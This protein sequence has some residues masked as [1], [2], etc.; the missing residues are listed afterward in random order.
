M[1]GNG[2]DLDTDSQDGVCHVYQRPTGERR[3]QIH[4]QVQTSPASIVSVIDA[5]MGVRG[6]GGWGW[7]G[8][9]ALDGTRTSPD[10]DIKGALD[11][12]QQMR[13][14]QT[15]EGWSR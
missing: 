1:N 14:R 8:T 11:A 10:W 2:D 5:L 15:Q 4:T 7:E 3:I 13:S 12:Y 9:A 6:V